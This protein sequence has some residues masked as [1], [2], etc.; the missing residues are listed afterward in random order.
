M[1]MAIDSGRRS[2]ALPIERDQIHQTIARPVVVVNQRLDIASSHGVSLS[3]AGAGAPRTFAL[4]QR[5]A[6]II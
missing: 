6:A 3:P 4:G 1:R 2:R 5:R